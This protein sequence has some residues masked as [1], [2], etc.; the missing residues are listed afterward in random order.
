MALRLDSAGAKALLLTD[1]AV[2][3]ALLE[4]PDWFYVSDGD[5]AQSAVTRHALLPDLVDR[6]VIVVC[7]HYP[8]S[9]IGR[10]VTR[11]GRTVWDEL[12]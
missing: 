2:H 8:G 3:P 1:C 5:P 12:R 11:E 7:G 4:Q 9:G 10:V 6:D